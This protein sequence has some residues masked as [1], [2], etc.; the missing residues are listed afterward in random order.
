MSDYSLTDLERARDELAR[1][2]ERWANSSSNNPD[3]HMGRIRVARRRLREVEDALKASGQLPLSDK[4][5]LEAR[6]DLAFPNARS[7]EIVEFEGK[8]YQRIFY[9]VERSR[10]RKTV[11]EWGKE[12]RAV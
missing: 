9:P 10:S 2:E 1:W 7:K 12:W 3:K 5:Q 6:L 11:N 4:E 8:K